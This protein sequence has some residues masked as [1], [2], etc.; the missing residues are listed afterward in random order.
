MELIDQVS[1]VLIWLIRAGAVFRLCYCL[2]RL[3]SADE[4]AVTYKKRA[5][6]TVVFYIIAESAFIIRDLVINH[7]YA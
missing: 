4:D 7:Y 2:F 1:K 6:H 3:I 5:K